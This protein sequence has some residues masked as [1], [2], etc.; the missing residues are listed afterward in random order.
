MLHVWL[1]L[2][3][4]SAC[5]TVAIAPGQGSPDSQVCS[6]SA[7]ELMQ[8]VTTCTPMQAWHKFLPGVWTYIATYRPARAEYIVNCA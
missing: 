2:L 6:N 4:L 3:A 7:I 1:Y 5:Q 8:Q